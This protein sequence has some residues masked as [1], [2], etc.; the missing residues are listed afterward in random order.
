MSSDQAMPSAFDPQAIE[1]GW[2]A[3]WEAAGLFR[4]DAQSRKPKFSIAVPP[5]NVTGELHLGTGTGRSRTPGAAT[6][7]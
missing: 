7:A 1:T 2:S 4:A 5:P 6:G 3:R